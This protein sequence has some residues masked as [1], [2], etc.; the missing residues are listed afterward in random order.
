MIYQTQFYSFA[1]E[2]KDEAKPEN[3]RVYILQML[4]G[5]PWEEIE[6]VLSEMQET[7]KAMKANALKAEEERLKLEKQTV[8]EDKP[9]EPE[10]ING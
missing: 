7:F 8:Y 3:N 6:S 5:S 4:P 2:R 9:I 10:V 1:A